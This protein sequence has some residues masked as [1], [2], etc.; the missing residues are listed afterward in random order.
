[1]LHKT[2][3]NLK[4]FL[5]LL[6]TSLILSSCRMPETA[7][8]YNPI[9]MNVTVPDG[10]PEYKAGWYAG[11]KSGLGVKSFANAW[12]YQDKAGGTFGSGVYHHDPNFQ[13]GW[14]QGWFSCSIH[15]GMFVNE[16][17]TKYGP[18]Q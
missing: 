3:K 15:S 17:S 5:L 14:G 11:C 1:M 2:V 9:T 12:V 6:L 10:P 18:L 8:F 4:I 16:H 7:G 13:T